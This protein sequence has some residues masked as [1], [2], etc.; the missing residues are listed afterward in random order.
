MPEDKEITYK[1]NNAEYRAKFILKTEGESS[2]EILFSKSAIRGM[3]IEENFLEPFTFGNIY[4]NNP[5]DFIEDGALIRGDGRDTFS[6]EFYPVDSGEGESQNKQNAKEGQE[7]GPMKLKYDFVISSELNSVSKTDRLNNFKTYTLLEKNYFKLNEKIPYGTRFRGNVGAIIRNIFEQFDIPVND[8][9]WEYGDMVINALPEHILPPTTFRY[10]DLIK[11]LLKINYKK[12]GAG[13]EDTY[14]RII[15]NYCRKCQEYKYVAL[16]DYFDGTRKPIEGFLA[17]DLVDKIQTNPN[18]PGTAPGNTPHNKY[19]ATLPNS[20]LSSP[21][22]FYTNAFLNNML[23][24]S[25]NPIL[26][27][28]VMKLLRISEIKKKWEKLFV[29]TFKYQG[30]KAQP[31]L[32]LNRVKSNE[33]FRNIGFPLPDDHATPLA[34]AELT[35]NMTFFNLQLNFDTLGNVDRQPGEF[36]DVSSTRPTKEDDGTNPFGGEQVEHRSDAKLLGSWFITKVRHEFNSAKVDGYS[37]I[38]Q[39][40]KPHIGPNPT[41]PSDCIE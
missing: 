1:I 23:V 9:D 22:L 4:I 17:N 13:G 18:N 19:N 10:S 20:D 37:N 36:V 12:V 35:A 33:L 30:G 8:V 16:S 21:M 40:I 39:C 11:Y 3:D 25:Y 6:K 27:E 15:L 24:S 31:W 7:G 2:E 26:G 34:E 28:H 5:L 41:K 32:V 38:L 14:V 29:D